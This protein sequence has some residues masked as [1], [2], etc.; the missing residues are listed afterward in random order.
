MAGGG[1]ARKIRCVLK[2][3]GQYQFYVDSMRQQ[4][5]GRLFQEFL[6]LKK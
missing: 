4:G 6:E 2:N 5:E 1:C 3:G